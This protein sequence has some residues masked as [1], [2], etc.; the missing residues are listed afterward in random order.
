MVPSIN[1]LSQPRGPVVKDDGLWTWNGGSPRETP[2]DVGSN[3]TGAIG[4]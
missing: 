1:F 4:D 2:V 3:P